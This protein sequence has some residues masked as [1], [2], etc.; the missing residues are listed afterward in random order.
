MKSIQRQEGLHPSRMSGRLGWR[1]RRQASRGQALVEFAL[2]IPVM[3]LMLVIAIDFGR[4][5]FSYVAITNAAREGAAIGAHEPSNLTQIQTTAGQETSSQSQR[6][7][8]AL[9][10]TTVC[11]DSLGVTLVNCTYASGGAA[12]AGNTITVNVD[13][14]FTFLTPMITAFFPNLHMKAAAT[15]VVTDYASSSGG[16]VPGACAAPV[17]NFDVNVT[18]GRTVFANPT[19][20]RPNSGT[21][22]ISG[23][24]WEWDP[25]PANDTVGNALGDSHT[26]LVDGTY[27][28]TL[29][30]T[31]QGGANSTSK[32]VVVPAV[33]PP[34]CTKPVANF[35]WTTSGKTYTYTDASTVTDNVNCPITAWLWTFTDIGGTQSNAKNPAPQDYGNNSAHPVT[36]TVTNAAGST[37]ITKNS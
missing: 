32:S 30:V 12:G 3:L 22:N 36:L 9:T 24:N 33:A 13:E 28:I 29:T 35:T 4:M 19:A 10:V 20:S 5:F 18:S 26:Y 16:V 8:N 17:A 15:A 6:G 2:I 23:F 21:C 25:D 27:I 14:K 7:E 31:N 1:N 11:K 34:T 37:T